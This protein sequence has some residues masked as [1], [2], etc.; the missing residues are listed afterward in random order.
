MAW[1]G[2]YE[3]IKGLMY[4]WQGGLEMGNAV[5]DVLSGDVTPSGKLVDTIAKTYG[6]YPASAT[7]ANN[8]G[9][10]DVEK[11][12]EDIYVGYRYFETFAKDRV[13][14]PFGYG[15]SYTTFD[16]EAV[17]EAEDETITVTATV[18]NTGDTYS[19]KE[20]VE[21]YYAA[22]QGKLGK[23][24]RALAGYAKTNEIA[25]GAS[26][27]VKISIPTDNMASYDDGGKTG[28]DSAW[29]LEA[30]DYDIYVG[31]SVRTAE[32]TG[33]WK[34]DE[35]KVVEQLEEASAL[36]QAF[37]RTVAAEAEDGSPTVAKEAAP[38]V[39][40]EADLA[41]RV[42]ENLPEAVE[43]TGDK[44]IKLIDVYNGTNTMDEFIAQLTVE[45]LA[46]LARGDW[47]KNSSLVPPSKENA[48]A[49]GGMLASLR[50]KGVT[51]VSTHDGPAGP[52]AGA[53]GTGLPI[54]TMLAC[55]WNDPLVE[56]L[57][58]YSGCEM[59]TSSGDVW[60]AP[61]MNIHRDP[62]GGRN[63]E[64]YSEDPVITG[65]MGAAATRGMQKAGTG[66]PESKREG[67]RRRGNG[68]AGHRGAAGSHGY[69]EKGRWKERLP[70]NL[71]R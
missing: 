14:Y 53:A 65:Q 10:T 25:P 63:F 36:H 40:E 22:P 4:A 17:V 15:L 68:R 37:D 29:V 44:G 35:L 39:T 61:G 23:P 27:T 69:G 7:F 20:V 70:H 18:T 6:D 1:L 34:L 9:R 30:G 56:K 13:L 19:G 64:Y 67:R 8:D 21:V 57:C 54:G 43:Q 38:T 55:T 2:D 46:A 48:S 33:T 66:I 26:Q 59:V 58:Y 3:N 31:N 11:Y 32:K 60:L 71:Y 51:A 41:A 28:H 49:F 5:A 12:E 62:L 50:E 45:E 47:G 52:R 16:T 42:L 24:A